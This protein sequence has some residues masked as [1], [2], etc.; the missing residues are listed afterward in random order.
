MPNTIGFQALTD[1]WHANAQLALDTIALRP[2][3]GIPTWL[4]ND[5]QLNALRSPLQAPAFVRPAQTW[6]S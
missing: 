4:L 6:P 3:R 5:A 2:T 1:Q